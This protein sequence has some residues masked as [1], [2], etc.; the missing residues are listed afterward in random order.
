LRKALETAARASK[1]AAAKPKA[2]EP[3][4]GRRKTR[5]GD[6]GEI[7]P[8]SLPSPSPLGVTNPTSAFSSMGPAKF[9]ES[10]S[11]LSRPKESQR[12]P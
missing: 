3:R 7:P 6:G 8:A 4:C 11:S 1:A 2:G 9:K 5:S 12:V 10:D